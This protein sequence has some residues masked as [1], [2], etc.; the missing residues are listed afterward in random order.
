MPPPTP[1]PLTW[2]ISAPIHRDD[3]GAGPERDHQ[4]ALLV[5]ERSPADADGGELIHLHHRTAEE[6]VAERARTRTGRGHAFDVAKVD[7]RVTDDFP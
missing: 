5:R 3:R 7:A 4:R 2:R 1:V 6:L